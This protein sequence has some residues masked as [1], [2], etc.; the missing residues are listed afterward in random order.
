MS[1]PDIERNSVC[2]RALIDGV[3]V[4]ARIHSELR[5]AVENL[6]ERG[7][8]PGLA[9]VLVGSDSASSVYVRTKIRRSIEAGLRL[10]HHELPSTT[11]EADLLSLI[12]RLNTA[13][14]VHGILVQLPLPSHIDAQRIAFAIDPTKDVD[15]LHPMN[16]GKLSIGADALV[17]CTPL[18]CM[19]L[20]KGVRSQLAGLHAVIVGRSNIVGKPLAQ[21]LLRENCT[22]TVAHSKTDDLASVCRRSDILVA[23]VGQPALIRGEW[24]KPGAIVIDVGIN[25]IEHE[26]R[27]RLVGDVDFESVRLMAGALTPVP[28]GVGPMTIAC[29]LR[30]TIEAACRRHGVA[31]PIATT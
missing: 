25:R 28:G 14:D 7:L 16:V 31:W 22:V 6:S 29:L 24:I 1:I 17:P 12:D 2:E 26:G 23:A 11:S 27:R 4:A 20:I 13:P 5:S 18:G 21:L 15:G 9:V 3:A 8:T 10:F 19:L 30:N